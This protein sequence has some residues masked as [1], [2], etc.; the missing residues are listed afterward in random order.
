MNID[1]VKRKSNRKFG[2]IEYVRNSILF[3]Y[4]N[5]MKITNTYLEKDTFE[6]ISKED[7][8]KYITKSG[9]TSWYTHL[10][11]YKNI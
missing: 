3:Y 2:I 6:V 5:G 9:H 10:E 7:F 8:Q 1:F 4:H 11:R